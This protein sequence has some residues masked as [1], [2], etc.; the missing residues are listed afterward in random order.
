MKIFRPRADKPTPR[1]RLSDGVASTEAPESGS[2]D[3]YLFRRN[4][5]ITGSRSPHVASANERDAQLR[6]PRS[7][8]HAL[9]RRRRSLFSWLLLS[10]AVVAGCLVILYQYS[11]EVR[12]G[13][14][15]Q[16]SA[17]EEQQQQ[18]YQDVI[19]D[20]LSRHP[21]ERLR[22]WLNRQQLADY[23]QQHEASEVA[24]V[25]DARR[26][27]LGVTTFTL[28]MREP[29][30]SWTVDG[31]EQ[32]VDASGTIFARNY[33]NS[34]AVQI[35]D[36]SGVQTDDARTVA[37]GRFLSF[38][39]Q[40]IGYMNRFQVPAHAVVIPPQ[41]TR[42]LQLQLADGMRIKFSID[43]PAGQQAEDA[44]RAVRYFQGQGTAVEY[45]D[46][47][48]SSKAFYKTR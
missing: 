29:L 28:K 19:Q 4:Q 8:A 12:V 16:V 20:Y 39:G 17:L 23:L 5:T 7:T 15:G 10:L 47:R 9:H 25:V 42:Q 14:E 27:G 43:R 45:I 35:I 38:I 36:E 33:Y 41:T 44:A 48:V 1:R 21:G 22:W 24:D 31:R 46:V 26:S 32:F 18:R 13:L 2:D 3:S 40:S 34:P 6:S 37:S 30:A 11:A